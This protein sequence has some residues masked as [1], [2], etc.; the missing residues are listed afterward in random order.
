ML[1]IVSDRLTDKDHLGQLREALNGAWR[2]LG[3]DECG[4][5]RLLGSRVK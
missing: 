4:I 2:S 3:R 5:W 1:D